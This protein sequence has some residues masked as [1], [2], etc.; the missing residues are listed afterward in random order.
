M[1]EKLSIPCLRRSKYISSFFH[2]SFFLNVI[3]KLFFLRKFYIYHEIFLALQLW[4][5]FVFPQ[6][7]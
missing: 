6:N 1:R 3:V 4:P 2:F 7:I 5:L